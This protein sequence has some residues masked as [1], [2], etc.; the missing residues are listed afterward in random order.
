MDLRILYLYFFLFFFFL[1]RYWCLD[2]TIK[3]LNMCSNLVDVHH[4]FKS[5]NY[6]VEPF[7]HDV[8]A[9]VL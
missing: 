8:S 9:L 1:V 3:V 4:R 2:I 5:V 6:H 7:S